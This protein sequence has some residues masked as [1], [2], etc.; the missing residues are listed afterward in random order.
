M[1]A[2]TLLSNREDNNR[3]IMKAVKLLTTAWK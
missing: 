1:K 2:A 3:E